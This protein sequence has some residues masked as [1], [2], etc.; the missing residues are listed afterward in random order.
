MGILW[1]AQNLLLLFIPVSNGQKLCSDSICLPENYNRDVSPSVN[2]PCIIE[3]SF[4]FIRILKVYDKE[5][6]ITL[7]LELNLKWRDDRLI[8]LKDVTQSLIKLPSSIQNEIWI[9]DIFIFGLHKVNQLELTKKFIYM[10]QS[11]ATHLIFTNDFEIEMFCNMTFEYFPFDSQICDFLITS[12]SSTDTEILFK[13]NSIDYQKDD[14][15]SH[16]KYH[17]ANVQPVKEY[18]SEFLKADGLKGNW[19][20]TGFSVSLSRKRMKFIVDYF[21][22]SGLLVIISWVIPELFQKLILEA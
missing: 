16:V 2:G 13:F 12:Y 9:P 7:S 20:I 22:P 1:I 19:S 4:N 10:Y 3:A 18:K 17:I 14:Q 6:T 11:N 5:S 8:F 15:V 21:M